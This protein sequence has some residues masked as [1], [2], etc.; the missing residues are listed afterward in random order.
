MPPL[1]RAWRIARLATLPETRRLIVATA[2]PSTVRALARRVRE[3]R[4]GVVRDLVHPGNARRL[5]SQAARHPAA[6]ELA[7]A[8]FL[9]LPTRYTPVGWVATCASPIRAETRGHRTHRLSR[10]YRRR[11]SGPSVIQSIAVPMIQ[12]TI[13]TSQ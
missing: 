3:D 7:N 13:L 11:R 6:A 9:L 10:G 1:R 12:A 4:A 5:I 2:K 8:G